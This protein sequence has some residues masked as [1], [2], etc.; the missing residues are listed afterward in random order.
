MYELPEGLHGGD[1]MKVSEL[2]V[3]M[4]VHVNPSF[5]IHVRETHVDDHGN[6]AE[7]FLVGHLTHRKPKW[8]MRLGGWEQPEPQQYSLVYLGS[9]RWDRS[10]M[11]TKTF[12]WFLL[13][14]RKFMLSGWDVRALDP[15]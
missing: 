12:R 14:G 2:E 7:A 11:G 6:W 15:V 1:R 4:L 10:Y 5:Y 9:E 13:D 3:G 8:S